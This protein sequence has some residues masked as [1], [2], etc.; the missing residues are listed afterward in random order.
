MRT[1]AFAELPS[2]SIAAT[3]WGGIGVCERVEL[4]GERPEFLAARQKTARQGNQ[5]QGRKPFHERVAPHE[6]FA[7]L[8]NGLGDM[9]YEPTAGI[10]VGRLPKPWSNPRHSKA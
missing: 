10:L 9:S 4:R 6:S 2:A 8:A 7:R 3:V 5:T 1:G